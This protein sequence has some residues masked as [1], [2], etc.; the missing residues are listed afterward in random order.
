MHLKT[1]RTSA[2]ALTGVAALFLGACSAA[3]DPVPNTGSGQVTVTS[4]ANAPANVPADT[5]AP[6]PVTQDREQGETTG[7]PC[8]VSGYTADAEDDLRDEDV[9]REEVAHVVSETCAGNGESDWDDD[10]YW[11]LELGDIDIDIR[12]DGTVLEIDR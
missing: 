12:P 2:V 3:N 9:S 11:E 5:P 1:F 7:Q 8:E 4:T 10:G 6:T